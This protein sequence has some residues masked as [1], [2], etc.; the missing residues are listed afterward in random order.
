ME[1]YQWLSLFGFT[2][3]FGAILIDIYTRIKQGS[4]KIV[5]KK[6]KENKEE[7]VGIIKG[8]VQEELKPIKK[9]V[10]EIKEE[11]TIIKVDD[12]NI[13]RAANRDSLRNQ[14]LVVFRE[15]QSKGYKTV[16]DTRNFEYMF[17]SYKNLGGNSFMLDIAEQMK[18]IPSKVEYIT[19]E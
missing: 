11:I 15:C 2:A 8:V 5:E 18:H 19:E 1:W 3:L 14:L 17:D 7:L 10:V 4:K 6:K 9:D 16:E 12:I 13:L